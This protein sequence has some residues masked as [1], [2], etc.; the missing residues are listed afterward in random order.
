MSVPSIDSRIEAS[1][2]ES[3]ADLVRESLAAAATP[4]ST[5]RPNSCRGT[6]PTTSSLN[7][8][9]QAATI[10]NSVTTRHGNGYINVRCGGP[11]GGSVNFII[12]VLGYYESTVL[13]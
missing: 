9:H 2:P 4:A 13:L 7:W 3:G 1:A 6:E 12:D 11:A 5:A 10:A 8:D